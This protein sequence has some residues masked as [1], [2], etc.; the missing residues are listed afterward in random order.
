[1]KSLTESLFDDN[2]VSKDI[3]LGD[4]YELEFVHLQSPYC[5]NKLYTKRIISQNS[6]LADEK[7]LKKYWYYYGSDKNY[8][9]PPP[10][11]EAVSNVIIGKIEN[12]PMSKAQGG[13]RGNGFSYVFIQGPND[14]FS[15]AL[16][17]YL[18]EFIDPYIVAMQPHQIYVDTNYKYHKQEGYIQVKIGKNT[19]RGRSSIPDS[20]EI[21]FRKK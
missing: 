1:M 4:L 13:S 16:R 11:M 14:P 17:Q 18:H 5:F 7:D 20:I 19:N 15:N 2:L 12:F 8:K 3:R 10:E 9:T 21:V 6:K